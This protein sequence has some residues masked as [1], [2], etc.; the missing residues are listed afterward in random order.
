MTFY[1]FTKRTVRSAPLSSTRGM[2]PL[3]Y[4]LLLLQQE[5]ASF[6]NLAALDVFPTVSFCERQGEYPLFWI[7]PPSLFSHAVRF[8]APVLAV[9]RNK[10]IIIVTSAFM[11]HYEV[12]LLFPQHAY[13]M[14][15]SFAFLYSVLVR[16][17]ISYPAGRVPQLSPRDCTKI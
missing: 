8:K 9:R 5:N 15:T 14:D 13:P 3:S 7:C 2:D 4:R 1:F 11:Q 6:I 17:S 16:D 10:C 12:G